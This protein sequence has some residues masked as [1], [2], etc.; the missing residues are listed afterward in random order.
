LKK[1]KI[2]VAEDDPR[3]REYLEYLLG[4]TGYEVEAVENGA[5]ALER[6]KKAR[7]DLIISDILMPVMDGFA[8]VQK[9]RTDSST[10]SI[11]VIF[12]SATYEGANLEALRSQGDITQQ[13]HKPA[14]PNELLDAVKHA[15]K[16]QVGK[17]ETFDPSLFTEEHIRALSAKV[18]E[19]VQE[20]TA[21]N[22][23][24]E[25]AKVRLEAEVWART[26]SEQELR[27]TEQRFLIAFR[28]SP[29]PN[30][31]ST[32]REGRYLDVND[33]FLRTFGYTREEVLG[34]SAIEIGFWAD[35]ADREQLLA[36]LETSG[37]V[38]NFRTTIFTKDRKPRKVMIFVETIDLDGEACVLA[39]TQDVTENL[40]L[41]EQLR[42]AQ[43]MEAIGLLAGGIAHDFNNLLGVMMG[44]AELVAERM[45]GDEKIKKRMEEIKTASQRA[46]ALTSQLLAFSRQQ[47]LSPQVINL[48]DVVRETVRMLERLIGE[49]I[50]VNVQ[51]HDGLWNITADSGQIQQVILNL[52]VNA[53]DAMPKG[54]RLSIETENVSLD[55]S[56]ARTHLPLE[57]GEYVMLRVSD[58]G[59]GMDSETQSRIFEPFF[60]TKETGKGTGLG[61]A[62]SYGIVKQS[63]GYIWVYSEINEGTTFKVYLPRTEKAQQASKKVHAPEQASLGGETI[64]VAE[65]QKQYMDVI[66]DALTERGYKVI[67]LPIGSGALD[68]LQNKSLAPDLLLSDVIMPEINGV[69][70]AAKARSSFPK[71]KVIY[72]SG[73]TSDVIDRTGGLES[74]SAFL[75]KP[76][77]PRQLTKKVREVLDGA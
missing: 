17:K 27:K 71:I 48:N 63:G 53:R 36:E 70:L 72:M 21:M 24:L 58:T 67:A 46:A 73:Y 64:L 59:T 1:Y 15:L 12:Y 45:T 37:S 10:A 42:R 11:P 35:L 55:A 44:N 65:D 8:L 61:L 9:L 68:A 41:E 32:R 49:D 76:F 18:V 23:E 77:S 60:T 69:E 4:Q 6:V 75:Q 7:P 43:K 47:V 30:T 57:P 52:A 31:I 39:V 16:L 66:V 51:F 14:P 34:H 25:E 13:L 29:V 50:K 2:L 26:E 40:Q 3:S 33:S 28:S 22:A 56:Y 62:T 5:L 54:G 19:K 38:K 20:L 74:N